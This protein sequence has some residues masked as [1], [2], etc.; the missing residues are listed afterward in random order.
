MSC[1][2]PGDGVRNLRQVR[3]LYKPPKVDKLG[4]LRRRHTLETTYPVIICQIS[5]NR[6]VFAPGKHTTPM[7]YTYCVWN[8]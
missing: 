1:P 2:T 5:S 8:N 3:T 7:I 6:V 4:H